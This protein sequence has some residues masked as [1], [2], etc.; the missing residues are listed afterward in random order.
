MKDVNHLN[1]KSLATTRH[2]GRA[3]LVS[4]TGGGIFLW[5]YIVGFGGKLA[6]VAVVTWF[7]SL[8]IAVGVSLVAN[9]VV[10][11]LL[12]LA[13]GSRYANVLT[14]TGVAALVPTL[15]MAMNGYQHLPT[16]MGRLAASWWVGVWV[17]CMASL[18]WFF[19]SVEYD[20]RSESGQHAP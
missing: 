19:T 16:F 8:P 10:A 17:A 20:V 7:I 5:F 12:A 4:S 15:L 14:V 3:F 11:P 9:A 1:S 6:V 2:A 13:W 18:F